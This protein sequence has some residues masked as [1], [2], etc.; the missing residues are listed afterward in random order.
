V[1]F[2]VLAVVVTLTG[3]VTRGPITPVCREGVPCSEPAANVKLTFVRGSTTVSVRTD[4]TG[5]YRVRLAPGTYAVRTS[6]GMSIAPAKV[7]VRA[8]V[9]HRN[10]AIDTG[11]R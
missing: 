8:A 7:W 5:H 2:A 3:S 11:I 10:F 6:A 1:V 9:P 4:A